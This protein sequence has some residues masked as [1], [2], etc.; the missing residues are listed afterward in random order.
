VSFC[1]NILRNFV[2]DRFGRHKNIG[3]PHSADSRPNSK[4]PISG[5]LTVV[6]DGFA[7]TDIQTVT[8]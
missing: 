1:H 2:C 8:P 3:L 7:C 5:S 6:S 4:P